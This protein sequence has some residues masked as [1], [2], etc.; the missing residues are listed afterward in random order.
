MVL[1]AWAENIPAPI[2]RVTAALARVRDEPMAADALDDDA[3]VALLGAD[4]DELDE[5]CE[6]ADSV[7][8]RLTDPQSLTFVVNRNF[9]T[10]VVSRLGPGEPSLAEL[11]AEALE[12]G[13][14]EICMQGPVPDK[15]PAER[16]VELVAEITGAADGLHLHA[17]RPPELLDGARRSGRALG[18]H[19]ERLRLAGLGSFPGTAAQI[20][21]DEVRAAL[22][23]TGAAAPVAEWIDVV[24]R[25]HGAGLSS[26][27][28]MLYGHLESPRHQV[29]HLRTLID[30]ARRTGGFTELIVMPLPAGNAPPHLATAATREVSERETRAVHA[31]A[32]LMTAGTIDH[33]QV[34]WTKLPADTVDRVLRGGADDI[35]GLLLDGTLM[36]QAGPEAG[37]V[38]DVETLVGIADRAGRTL[39][40]RTTRYGEPAP[41][42]MLAVPQGTP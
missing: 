18:D 8:A 6:I 25:A 2:E 1:R 5:L 34:A 19:L 15:L 16:Y 28:T 29:A 35:G 24:E 3:W 20:L 26:T 42:Q 36:P 39:R 32:R 41:D 30:I 27:A 4:G 9:D 21:D 11:V 23:P 31:V 22:S 37:R 38:L 10:C 7:R 33:L 13:A 14:T 40:Q 12:L 17:Y